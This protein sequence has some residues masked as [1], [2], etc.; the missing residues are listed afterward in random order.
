M[1]EKITTMEHLDKF[2]RKNQNAI[3]NVSKFERL[4]FEQRNICIFFCMIIDRI[5]ARLDQIDSTR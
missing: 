1:E 3:R 2:L 5:I 4:A